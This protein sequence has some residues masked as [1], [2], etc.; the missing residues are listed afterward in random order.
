[1][2]CQRKPN[3]AVE[4]AGEHAERK[5]LSYARPTNIT[6]EA[7]LRRPTV[8][9]FVSECPQAEVERENL[10]ER[11]R[12][13]AEIRE[14]IETRGD[15]ERQLVEMSKPSALNIRHIRAAMNQMEQ[16]QMDEYQQ[17]VKA[18]GGTP[19]SKIKP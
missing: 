13:L 18:C 4:L 14:L 9:G 6:R 11:E 1:M 5:K 2:R 12:L 10:K 7:E 3:R 16:E 19:I 8:I 15:L 17:Y